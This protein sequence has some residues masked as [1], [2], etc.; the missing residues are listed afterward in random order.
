M[1]KCVSV[2]TCRAL[3]SLV[4]MKLGITKSV[5]ASCS[6]TAHIPPHTQIGQHTPLLQFE[7]INLQP[8]LALM[9]SYFI[10]LPV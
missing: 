7:A 2:I 8:R 4:K 3:T 10:K 1:M 9:K 6:I 5:I